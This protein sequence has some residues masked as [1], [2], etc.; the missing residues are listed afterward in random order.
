MSE[1]RF[2]KLPIN[3]I[4]QRGFSLREKMVWAYC[5]AYIANYPIFKAKD[6]TM[7]LD[8]G[9]SVQMFQ[10]TMSAIR[11]KTG[12]KGRKFPKQ[13]TFPDKPILTI[14]SVNPDHRVSIIETKYKEVIETK[15]HT[16]G[17]GMVESDEPFNLRTYKWENGKKHTPAEID[18]AKK[19]IALARAE[20]DAKFA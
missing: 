9:M 3:L 4:R 19:V 1:E 16:I 18:N 17:S 8:L 13:P 10:K 15:E 7:A 2:V 11:R 5:Q 20:Y 6:A 14:E 12:L